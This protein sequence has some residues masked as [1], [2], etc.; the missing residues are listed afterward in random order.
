MG[1]SGC[2]WCERA[3]ASARRGVE[4]R[5]RP[6]RRVGVSNAEGARLASARRC[7]TPR[8]PA[9]TR[10]AVDDPERPAP[11]S[12]G[13]SAG[14]S[15]R[16]RIR[17][18]LVPARRSPRDDAGLRVA[19]GRPGG[20]VTESMVMSAFRLEIVDVG[21]AS[22]GPRREVVDVAGARRASAAGEDAGRRGDAEPAAQGRGDAVRRAVEGEWGAAH[23]VRAPMTSPRRPGGG[24]CQGRWDHSRRGSP[25]RHS[26]RAG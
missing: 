19:R 21:A 20:F 23:R 22:V 18:G 24:R 16:R 4:R 5:R 1:S 14:S 3:P 12:S 9:P 10:G 8:A 11:A 2:R 25:H 15:E 26:P 17:F 7:M 13:R 6:P